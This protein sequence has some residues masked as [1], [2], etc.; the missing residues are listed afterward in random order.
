MDQLWVLLQFIGLSMANFGA[1]TLERVCARK[2]YREA[3]LFRQWCRAWD[4][5]PHGL[6]ATSS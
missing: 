1:L 3:G 5:N 6:A 2:T 4:S